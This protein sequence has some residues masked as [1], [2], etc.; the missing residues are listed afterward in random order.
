MKLQQIYD[1]I[2]YLAFMD[3]LIFSG[4]WVIGN[5]YFETYHE[6]PQNAAWFY[7]ITMGFFTVVFLFV[8]FPQT[9]LRFYQGWK[10][11]RELYP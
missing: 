5:I 8:I 3:I 1:F 11:K 2:T 4:G 9:L 6:L 7:I 10:S